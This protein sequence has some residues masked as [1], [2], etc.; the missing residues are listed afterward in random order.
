MGNW[1]RSL[2]LVALVAGLVLTMAGWRVAQRLADQE[3]RQ[4][5]ESHVNVTKESIQAELAN[6]RNIL[7]GARGLF[8]ASE[9]VDR[10]EFAAYFRGTGVFEEY[11][12]IY[13]YVYALRVATDDLEDFRAELEQEL[14]SGLIE[15][16]ISRTPA[17]GEDHYLVKYIAYTHDTAPAAY[18]FDLFADGSRREALEKA[19]DS[20]QPTASG[21][22][23]LK[24]PEKL[25][26][27]MTIP[28]YSH[29]AEVGTETQR[30]QAIVGFINAAFVYEDLMDS[31]MA[32]VEHLG[33]GG[34]MD[35]HIKDEGEFVYDSQP[36]E[37]NA[38]HKQAEDFGELGTS[39]VVDVGGRTWQFSFFAARKDLLSGLEENLPTLVLVFGVV[40]SLLVFGM[41]YSLSSANVRAEDLAHQM[42]RELEK[43]KMAVE[44]TSEHIVITDPEARILYANK[45]VE[46][47]TGYSREEIIGQ[48]PSLWGKQMPQDFYQ[49]MWETIKTHKQTFTGEVTNRRKD[50]S[51]YWASVSIA[52]I[53]DSAG[54]VEFFVGVERDI[55]HERSEKE[56]V[57]KQVALRT[58]ELMSE[59]A[60][61]LASIEAL[62]KA[63]IM[64]DVDG[65]IIL[66]NNNVDKVFGEPG[67]EWTLAKLQER[68]GSSFDL[69]AAYHECLE[70]DQMLRNTVISWKN[71]YLEIRTSPVRG[72]S[73]RG[74]R[75]G[76]LIIIGDVTEEKLLA[77][78]RDEF[79]SIAS[80]ELR[81]PLTAIRGNSDLI[82]QFYADRI[83]ETDFQ[84]MIA[85][86]HESAVRL[87]GIVSDFL[88]MSRLELGKITFKREQVD[89]EE[90]MEKVLRE[91]EVTG[92]RRKLGLKLVKSQK[93]LPLVMADADRLRQVV[94]NLVGNGLKFTDEGGITLAAAENGGMV[95]VSVTDTGRGIGPDNQNLL[96]RKFQQ[97]SDGLLTRD[98]TKGTGLGLYISRLMVEGMG[99]KIWLAKSEIGRGST[100]MFSLPTK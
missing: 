8:S 72:E 43:F 85:D 46:V 56:L 11:P 20:G 9:D 26:F 42:T 30:R 4:N 55:T 51:I 87:I 98:A 12:G 15:G 27:I 82:Q 89:I 47:L 24:G 92:S 65:K 19:R 44:G 97:A 36:G 54:E 53:L 32:R 96:F 100:F 99:G 70:G 39:R 25:G 86:I 50:G 90:L 91:F 18:G 2:D 59:K 33:M 75:I 41:A 63:F 45:A 77:R 3:L 14:D 28:V 81:T 83:K 67:G 22:V 48:R 49:K 17:D 31:I 37:E 16:E 58:A 5:L 69:N 73:D 35:V 29:G 1:K 60:K 40:G 76:V 7:I 62:M 57:E 79:F 52:P 71:R 80:H 93:K 38:E 34:A 94:I 78:S 23:I 6:Y 21:P 66:T 64:V 10:S 13:S 88:D 84:E 74:K 95:E 61:L 68:L